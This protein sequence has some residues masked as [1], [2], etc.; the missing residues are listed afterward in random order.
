M[1]LDTLSVVVRYLKN[2]CQLRLTVMMA[3]P[4]EADDAAIEEDYAIDWS[5]TNFKVRRRVFKKSMKLYFYL[6][7]RFAGPAFIIIGY[8]TC[9]YLWS[10][11]VMRSVSTTRNDVY[12]AQQ[13]RVLVHTYNYQGEVVVLHMTVRAV[14]RVS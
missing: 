8:L 10:S 3:D 11:V 14:L 9:T 13:R 4:D 1:P 12:Y 6:L 5:T 2:R 7:L